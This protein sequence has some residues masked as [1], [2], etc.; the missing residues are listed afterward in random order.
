MVG[1]SALLMSTVVSPG[2][3]KIVIDHN[4]N[5]NATAGFKFKHVPSPSR[6]DAAAKAQ[7]AIV[8]G[9]KDANGGDL[10]KLHDGAVPTE[11]DQPSAN[12]FFNAGTDGGRLLID[13]GRAIDIK[14]INTYSWHG[15]SRGPQVYQLYASDGKADHFNA[16]PKRGTDPEKCGWKLIAKVDTRPGTGEAGGQYGVSISDSEGTLGKYRQLLFDISRTETADPFG[17]TFY[18]EIDVIDAQA[19]QVVEETLAAQ[20]AV[21]TVE[22][23]GG[24]Y[25]ITLD[26]TE[27]PDLTEWVH[28]VLAPVAKEWYPI[29]VKML[30][31]EGYQAPTNLSIQFS[32]SMRGVAATSG[33][34]IR[35][36]ASWYRQN[37]KGEAVGSVVHEMVHVVQ[38]YG[39]GRRNN[40]NATSAP[41]WLTE[42]ITDY[43]RFYKFEPQTHGAEITQRNL[44]R[45]KYDASYRITANFLNWV[46]DKY[47]QDLLLQLNT[48]IR[49]GKYNEEFWKTRTGHTV[50]ELGDEWKASLEKKLSF[51]S[52]ARR[53]EFHEPLISASSAPR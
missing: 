4:A 10:D 21:E 16:Q 51:R 35:C 39:R 46:I 23:D 14:Q 50:P 37:L 7:F 40:P 48:V 30:P 20:P 17:N 2:E 11:E 13:L 15:G 31:S 33:T 19:P 42:G 53:G 52:P 49:E 36:A 29:L 8:D 12:M 32:K 25:L 27:T 34:R 38:Q 1:A 24:T 5:E 22:T 44:S 9:Q 26:T 3:I 28:Q 41:G 43:I 45:A 47:D 18:S 6:G